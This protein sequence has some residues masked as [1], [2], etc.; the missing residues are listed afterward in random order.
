MPCEDILEWGR[1]FESIHNRRLRFTELRSSSGH[2]FSVS[3]IFLGLDHRFADNGPPV[4]W[5]TMVLV[6]P[7][8]DDRIERFA[9]REEA[10]RYHEQTVADVLK[11]GATIVT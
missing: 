2:R 8:G 10:L 5:E 6:P 11:M 7:D 4:L 3:T 9:H 1:W